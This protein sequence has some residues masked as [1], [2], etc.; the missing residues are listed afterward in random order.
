MSFNR[1]A[2][3]PLLAVHDLHVDRGSKR[4]L[5]K[6]SF[7]LNEGEFVSVIG[8]SGCGKSTLLST[9][10][11]DIEPH[12]GSIRLPGSEAATQAQ[13]VAWMPQSDSLLPWLNVLDNAALGLEV[14]GMPKTRAAAR[15]QRLLEPF[16]LNDLGDAWPHELSGGMRQRVALLRTVALERPLL[17]LDE[18]FGALDALTRSQ[19]HDWLTSVQQ[20]FG[21]TVLL[22]THDVREAVILSDRVLVMTQ[23]PATVAAEIVVDLQRPRSSGMI[24][25]PA[26]ARIEGSVLSALSLGA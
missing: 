9:L 7:E 8:P 5:E 2:R 18:P 21:W 3:E 19:M 6:I 13:A 25:D 26:C 12:A 16:G 20:Q 11:G 4:V 22:V 24:A 15:V 1:V 14:E 17:L 23:Q 10:T